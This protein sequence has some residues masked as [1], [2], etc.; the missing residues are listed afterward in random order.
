MVGNA[1]IRVLENAGYKNIVV[2]SRLEIDL[3]N[4]RN[5][6]SFIRNEEIDVIINAAAKVGG[7][8]ANDK[9]PYDFYQLEKYVQ[10]QNN[11]IDAA[12]ENNLTK[13]IFL[14]GSIAFILNSRLNQLKRNT[15]FQDL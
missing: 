4:Q 2:K 1:L 10:I 7:I 9:L 8:L 6:K 12:V 13:F 14:G 11:L 3:T 5:T 15:C